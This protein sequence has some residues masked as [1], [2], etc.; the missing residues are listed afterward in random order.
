MHGKSRRRAPGGAELA[1]DVGRDG[2]REDEARR[3]RPAA[4]R[5]RATAAD[6]RMIGANRCWARA[7]GHGEDEERRRRRRCRRAAR[8]CGEHAADPH[9]RGRRVADDAAGPARIR[10]RDDRDEV[11]DLHAPAEQRVRGGAADQCRGDVVQECGQRRTRCASSASAPVQSSR[12]AARQRLRQAARLEMG[13][14]QREADE[15]QEEV[16]QDHPLVREVRREARR[17][18]AR[19]KQREDATR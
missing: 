10:R 1:P 19:G 13:R 2:A 18:R 9:H 16:R 15:Q 4:S 5:S 11:A 7:A 8:G 14:E 17:A 3:W 6:S 12:Q